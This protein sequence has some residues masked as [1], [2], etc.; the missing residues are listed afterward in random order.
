[1][2]KIVNGERIGTQARLS[3]STSAIIFDPTQQ[4]ILFYY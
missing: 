1:M 3:I 2:V 4:K